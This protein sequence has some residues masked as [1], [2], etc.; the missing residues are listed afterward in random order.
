MKIINIIFLFIICP[1]GRSQL[2]PIPGPGL[3]PS[4][5]TPAG[6]TLTESFGDT[7]G[8]YTQPWLRGA[9]TPDAIIASPGTPLSN[10]ACVNSVRMT[11][12]GGPGYIYTAGS[13]PRLV[14]GTTFDM[15]ANVYV[16]SNGL[17]SFQGQHFLCASLD[18]GCGTS[19]ASMYWDYDGTNF[20]IVGVGTNGST[21]ATITLNA[22]HLLRMH[23]QSGAAN[24][25]VNADGG[26][27]HTFTADTQDTLYFVLGSTGGSLSMTYYVGNMY[28][29]S[30]VGGGFP[31]TTF[32]DFENSTDGTTLTSTIIANGTH[33]GNLVIAAHGATTTSM[34]VST[35]AQKAQVTAKTACGTNYTDSGGTRG[36][37][38]NVGATT[39]FYYSLTWVS[40]SDNATAGFWVKTDIPTSDTGFY[41][42]GS[43]A[44]GLG[45]DFASLM[46]SNGLMY[47]ETQANP[48]GSPDTGSKFSYTIS[49]WYYITIQFKKYI[50]GT[51][52][53]S[54][55]I[56]DTSAGLL[57]A[58]TKAAQSSSPSAPNEF[59]LGRGGDSGTPTASVWIDGLSLDYATG[60]FPILP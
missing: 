2:F 53:H 56:Y 50:D 35:A 48:N 31:P 7:G 36:I 44:N 8:T 42:M 41:A 14:S 25:Y 27:N 13:F 43:I 4:C 33:C 29:N 23:V 6:T 26:T 3:S 21:Q 15:Y 52:K 32:S 45:S 1:I 49:T 37:K 17:G 58:Q 40:T 12:S 59:T 24:S 54:F 39:S 28:V 9:G 16:T 57:S 34:T 10:T 5:V 51:T 38:F 20:G 19:A 30:A 47:L 11:I 55:N 46:I 60:V 22:W 18:T